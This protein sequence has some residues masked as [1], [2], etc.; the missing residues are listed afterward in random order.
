M[1]EPNE[2]H[3]R[4]DNL[5]KHVMVARHDAAVARTLAAAVDKDVSVLKANQR[6]H[7]KVLNA[8]RETQLEQG[9]QMREGFADVRTEMHEMRT[10]ISS[11]NGG[12]ADVRNEV[13]SL[14]GGLTEIT[15]LLKRPRDA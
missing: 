8:L 14:K 6:A 4:F 12:M 1:S 5:E 2:I 3:E 7:T 15:T 10:D 9:Q 13:S 11:L